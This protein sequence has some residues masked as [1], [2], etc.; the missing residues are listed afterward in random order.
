MHQLRAFPGE[1]LKAD[2]HAADKRC[3]GFHQTQGLVPVGKIERQNDAIAC[4]Q[5]HLVILGKF[6]NRLQGMEELAPAKVNL[7]LRVLGR[8]DDQLH[9]IETLMAP[10]ALYDSIQVESAPAFQFQCTDPTLPRGDENLV[11]QAARLFFSATEERPNVRITLQKRIPHAAGLG[12]GSSDA[13]ATLRLLDRFFETK[14]P[15]AKLL[16]MATELGS[17]VP[18]FLGNGAAICRGRGE[19]VEPS[20]LSTPLNLLLLK[21][22]FGVPTSWAYRR[23]GDSRGI[24]GLVN[25]PQK[26]GERVF[27]NDLERP[28]FEKFIFLAHLKSWLLAQPEIAIALMAGSGSTMFAILPDE[29]TAEAVIGRARAELDR[30]LWATYC[31]TL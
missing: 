3:D 2:L 29:K 10:I 24:P 27:Q 1:K 22:R 21:P 25:E 14:I 6:I 5:F 8:R 15:T 13:A 17:D 11:V 18:F 19:I 31:R 20:P 30:E 9:E 16:S 23:W 7:F 12:G 28:V 26:L 4:R